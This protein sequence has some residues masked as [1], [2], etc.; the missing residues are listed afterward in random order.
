MGRGAGGAVSANCALFE[1]QETAANAETATLFFRDSGSSACD[2]QSFESE[3]S[4]SGA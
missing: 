2:G 3:V 4:T 1:R